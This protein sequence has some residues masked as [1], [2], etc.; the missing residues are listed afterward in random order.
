MISKGVLRTRHIS[1]LI[2][3]EADE[4]LEHGFRA[5]LDDI[6]RTLPPSVQVVLVSATLPPDVL[7][8]S[9]N[10]MKDPVKILVKRD[11]LTLDFI[12][13][14][15]VSVEKEEWK[16]DTLCDLYESM[17]ITQAVIFVNSRKKA[18]WLS[19]RLGES[20]FIVGSIRGGGDVKQ[21]ARDD[22]MKKFRSGELRVLIATDVIARGIDVSQVSLVINYDVPSSRETYLHRIG[23]SGRFGRKGLAINFA[24][25]EDLSLLKDIEQFYGCTVDELPSDVSSLI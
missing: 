22:V 8:V 15:Y 25:D 19:S 23:R 21:Q 11:E 7:E 14:F 5:N 10:Y 24:K 17:A 3:D 2:I 16:F 6:F 1:T 13:Q 9:E 12:R 20:N 4:M 18:D